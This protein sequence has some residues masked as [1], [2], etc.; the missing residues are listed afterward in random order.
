M[1]WSSLPH[2]ATLSWMDRRTRPVALKNST[3]RYHRTAP[4]A[5]PD[6]PPAGILPP[7]LP[8]AEEL[9]TVGVAASSTYLG[10]ADSYARPF[11]VIHVGAFR[12]LLPP[13]PHPSV[14]LGI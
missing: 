10:Q 12:L 3:P 1:F 13:P 7:A 14:E 4:T 2:R 8:A 9:T 5:V 6:R 11:Q